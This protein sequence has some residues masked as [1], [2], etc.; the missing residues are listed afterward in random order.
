MQKNRIYARVHDTILLARSATLLSHVN[1][2]TYRVFK[3]HNT[4]KDYRF[5]VR[6]HDIVTDPQR[7]VFVC[8]HISR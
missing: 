3:F 2:K 8:R 7:D 1:L 4:E 6:L 5:Y